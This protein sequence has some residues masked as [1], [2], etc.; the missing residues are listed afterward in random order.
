MSGDRISIINRKAYKWI[1]L[2][3][4]SSKL[5]RNNILSSIRIIV[6]IPRKLA[7]LAVAYFHH[8]CAVLFWKNYF[9]FYFLLRILY[10]IAFLDYWVFG[11]SWW[12]AVSIILLNC[13]TIQDYNSYIINITKIT[14]QFW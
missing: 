9:G 13:C 14:I 3:F 4:I 5:S 11:N 12:Y 2:T 8:F 10:A 1:H 6:L 7:P